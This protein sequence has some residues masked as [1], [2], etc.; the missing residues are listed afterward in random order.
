MSGYTT[1]Q[2]PRVSRANG[3]LIYLTLFLAPDDKKIIFPTYMH[4]KRYLKRKGRKVETLWIRRSYFRIE[5]PFMHALA[6]GCF[7]LA[8]VYFAI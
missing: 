1:V 7:G 3:Q 5:T 4:S 8:L 2:V 6:L